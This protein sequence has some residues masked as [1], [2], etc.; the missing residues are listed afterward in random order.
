MLYIA[1]I[2][3]LIFGMES[4]NKDDDNGVTNN[5]NATTDSTNLTN[6]TNP[7]DTTQTARMPTN[8]E[9]VDLGL[10]VQWY[11]VNLGA[12]SSE[13]YGDYYAWGEVFPRSVYTWDT[14]IY[15]DYYYDGSYNYT[16]YKYNT[17]ADYGTVDNKTVLEAADDAATAVLG[18]D[19]R[20]PTKDEW[21]EL[22]DNTISEWTTENNVYGRKFTA[23]NG[24]SLFLPAGGDRNY[25]DMCFRGETGNYMSVSL[26]ETYPIAS[27]CMSFHLNEQPIMNGLNDRHFGVSVRAVRSQN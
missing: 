6:P 19:A 13:Q 21:Q 20:I 8:G 10:S 9:W 18:K 7:N 23:D 4:C 5:G 1:A 17:I 12:R 25:G 11:S 26:N 15:G 3:L 2:A 14:Y 22:L 27:W 16:L 24:N